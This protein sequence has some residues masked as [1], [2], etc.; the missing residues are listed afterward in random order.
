MP[1]EIPTSPTTAPPVQVTCLPPRTA[2][3]AAAPSAGAWA[4]AEDTPPI[5]AAVASIHIARYF[6]RSFKDFI[7][8]SYKLFEKVFEF[9]A[10]SYRECNYHPEPQVVLS[11]NGPIRKTKLPLQPMLR[12]RCHLELGIQAS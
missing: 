3:L 10:P 2:K 5:S 12:S 4:D 11:G 7:F 6:W 9:S 8:V 1:G